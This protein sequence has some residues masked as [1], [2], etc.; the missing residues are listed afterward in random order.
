[1]K[2][3]DDLICYILFYHALSYPIINYSFMLDI[4]GLYALIKAGY[5][6]S[7][8]EG[9]FCNILWFTMVFY[10]ALLYFELIFDMISYIRAN[11]P[12]TR[13]SYGVL[14]YGFLLGVILSSFVF[15]YG[16]LFYTDI[17][18]VPVLRTGIKALCYCVLLCLYI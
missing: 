10:H 4:I 15:F 1:M 14:F 18:Y 5:Q 16:G 2:A 9:L 12:S 3:Y 6:D 17:C 13:L 8:I 7:L 11:K